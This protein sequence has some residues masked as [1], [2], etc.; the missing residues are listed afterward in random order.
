M[1]SGQVEDDGAEHRVGGQEV[2][3]DF[4]RASYQ[5]VCNLA[6][7]PLQDLMSLGSEARFI[8]VTAPKVD[9]AWNLHLLTRHA[10]LDWFV[11]CSSASSLLGRYLL[12][13]PPETPRLQWGSG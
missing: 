12:L 13:M 9:G 5:S 1:R 7:V 10:P 6:V 11:M 8:S 3:W 2:A 4:I